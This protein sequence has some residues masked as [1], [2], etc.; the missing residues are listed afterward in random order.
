KSRG[1]QVVWQLTD[2]SGA[3]R[4]QL[5]IFTTRPDTLYGA[6]FA[7]LSAE[8]P[9]VAELADKDPGLQRFIA[10]S[11]KT[12]TA[13]AEIETAEK[14]GYK[15]V[16]EVGAGKGTTQDPVPAWLRSR[17]RY[18]GAPTPAIHCDKCGIVPV[19]EKDLPVELPEDVEFDKPGNPLD[20]HPT[21][22]HVT[23]PQC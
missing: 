10:E 4:G 9:L 15:P 5:E 7:A 12:G 13:A 3:D 19:P 2:A 18:R 23:C 8:H 1:A 16:G 6:S 14:I 11:R 17:Q 20:R 22:K 21:W